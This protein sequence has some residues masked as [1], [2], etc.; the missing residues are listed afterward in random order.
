VEDVTIGSG[1]KS[2]FFFVIFF[3]IFSS[4]SVFVFNFPLVAR[5]K[6]VQAQTCQN[7]D[8]VCPATCSLRND[9]DCPLVFTTYNI[10]WAGQTEER[11][12]R[13][14]ERIKENKVDVIG[15]QEM[16]GWKNDICGYGRNISDTVNYLKERLSLIGWS[17][18]YDS[19]L[20][21]RDTRVL[22][23]FPIESYEELGSGVKNSQTMLINV[24]SEIVPS[25]K[26]RLFNIHGRPVDKGCIR[27]QNLLQIAGNYNEYPQVLLGDFNCATDFVSS[28]NYKDSCDNCSDSINE[29][30]ANRCR[31]DPVVQDYAVDHIIVEGDYP[32]LIESAYIDYYR[33]DVCDDPDVINCTSD[34]FPVISK[35]S[36]QNMAPQCTE[37]EID[38]LIT[39]NPEGK[40]GLTATFEDDNGLSSTSFSC[41]NGSTWVKFWQEPSSGTEASVSVSAFLDQSC[42]DYLE[43]SGSRK[44]LMAAVGC[45]Y[46]GNCGSEEDHCHAGVLYY[47]LR[48]LLSFYGSSDSVYDMNDDTLVNGMDFGELLKLTE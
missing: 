27:S 28:T 8:C 29:E 42:I 4:A 23:R 24:G 18:P 43:E 44:I 1:M 37:F 48:E 46:F 5:Q 14:A 40:F 25:G 9:N 21:D 13:I 39:D 19:P 2:F 30:V 6:F 22:S 20:I 3:S 45:D 10:L 34:H 11:L 33:P 41:N 32:W 35:I 31:D 16:R 26:I 36:F 12:D 17:L 38:P 15:F 7:N 47:S